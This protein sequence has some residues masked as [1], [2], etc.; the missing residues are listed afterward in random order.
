MSPAYVAL[1]A[2]SLSI[3][4][5]TYRSFRRSRTYSR[6]I[7]G[8]TV[9]HSESLC[10]KAGSGGAT[11]KTGLPGRGANKGAIMVACIESDHGMDRELFL[12]F[13]LEQT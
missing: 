6:S 7:S 10:A 1:K 8:Y 4:C 2:Y 3:Y 5:M 12:S 13:S 11:D 9:I